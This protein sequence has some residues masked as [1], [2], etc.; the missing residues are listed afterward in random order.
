MAPVR[1]VAPESEAELVEAVRAS[2]R[3]WQ[4]AKNGL[5]IPVMMA[6]YRSVLGRADLGVSLSGPSGVFKSELAALAQAH[7]GADFTSRCL[8]GSWSSTE[9]ALEL[10]AFFAKDMILVVDDFAPQSGFG[11]RQKLNKKAER[12]FRAQGNGN[13]RG[14]MNAD[15]T[16]R[17]SKPPRGLI[18]STGEDVPQGHSLRARQ[19]IIE[20]GPGDI[21]AERLSGCQQDARNGMYACA[22]WGYV[23]WLAGR[24]DELPDILHRA[25][26]EGHS[27]FEGAHARTP[28]ILAHLCAGGSLFL[29]F[30]RDIGAI[31]AREQEEL[32]ESALSA[33][34]RLGAGQKQFQTANEPVQIFLELLRAALVGGG[35]H[36][37]A[38]DG[39]QPIHAG[40]WGWRE[41]TLG[42]G[43]NERTEW[44]PQGSRIG[45]VDGEDLFLEPRMAY[46]TAQR[47][48]G[49]EGDGLAIS[50]QT[51][52]KRLDERR[53]LASR[54]SKRETLTIRKVAEG[55][56]QEVLHLHAA[57]LRPTSSAQPDQPDQPD[58]RG[59]KCALGE[60]P[61][62]PLCYNHD[63]SERCNTSGRDGRVGQVAERQGSP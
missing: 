52:K 24:Y 33:L 4:I 46:S 19:A 38:L 20:V 40:A 13:G 18:L 25:V 28:E 51:L 21:I 55:A 14:R 1:L 58:Q 12:L 3:V 37:A 10:L 39:S 2:L 5:A 43:D 15:G 61:E 48:A 59:S 29:D 62:A 54:D 42:V 31:D 35:A 8:P 41:L 6:V 22:M 26:V 60:P 45:W 34:H 7:W 27:S 53:L 57:S 11:E 50:M 56:R 36:V 32:T 44:R 17:L 16:L 9:N 63:Q 47:V 30:A 49:T 23:R